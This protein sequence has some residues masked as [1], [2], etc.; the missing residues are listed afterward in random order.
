MKKIT[1]IVPVYNTHK[2]IFERIEMW[3]SISSLV[4]LIIIE[5]KETTEA[6]SV[7]KK[8]GAEYHSK[9]NGN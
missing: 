2:Y 6:K 4:S 5:D 3:S 1:F 7:A 9:K 8:I